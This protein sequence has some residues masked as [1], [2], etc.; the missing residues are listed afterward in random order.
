M[1]SRPTRKWLAPNSLLGLS[2]KNAGEIVMTDRP[3]NDVSARYATMTNRRTLL[4]AGLGLAAA[5]LVS[6]TSASAQSETSNRSDATP[7]VT[8][9]SVREEFLQ[10]K[11][12]VWLVPVTSTG[13]T[14]IRE[15]WGA[16]RQLPCARAFRHEPVSDIDIRAR[17][18]PRRCRAAGKNG[19]NDPCR[20]RCQS[21]HGRQA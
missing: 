17:R 18:T 11:D 6:T 1:S 21:R 12:L 20:L 16:L 5:S 15:G 7:P 3:G 19:A 14:E 8:R 9:L 10:L 13:M 2:S 4:G